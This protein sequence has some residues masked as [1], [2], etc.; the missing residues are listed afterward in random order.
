MGF[1]GGNGDSAY[2]E[3]A[4]GV[5]AGNRT[6][7]NLAVPT[8]YRTSSGMNL[9]RWV[10]RQREFRKAGRLSEDRRQKLDSLGMVW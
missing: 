9:G 6:C 8:K 2:K 10:T 4:V 3:A 5:D 7:G 1:A